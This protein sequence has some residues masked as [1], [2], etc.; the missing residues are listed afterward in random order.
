MPVGSVV[1]YFAAGTA[2]PAG[3]TLLPVAPVHVAPAVVPSSPL[4]LAISKF[5]SINVACIEAQAPYFI[6]NPRLALDPYGVLLVFEALAITQAWFDT[7]IEAPGDYGVP[8]TWI[9]RFGAILESHYLSLGQALT[10]PD[11]YNLQRLVSTM[12]R[13]YLSAPQPAANLGHAATVEH[14]TTVLLRQVKAHADSYAQV[15]AP[16]ENRRIQEGSQAPLSAQ[17]T[18]INPSNWPLSHETL[19]EHLLC[20]LKRQPLPGSPR[21]PPPVPRPRHEFKRPRQ[22]GQN[23]ERG[24]GHQAAPGHFVC[25]YCTQD[26][27]VG[28]GKVHNKACPGKGQK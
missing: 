19:R 2:I 7:N 14:V 3:G 10:P 12:A 18:V 20:Q 25:R 28:T 22:P 15:L 23:L 24:N 17:G 27:P 16:Y 26:V 11:L 9:V 6:T 21:K 1:V 4:V 8:G 5:Q 13:V